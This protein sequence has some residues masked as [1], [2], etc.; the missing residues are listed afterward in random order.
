ME[1]TIHQIGE[2]SD[3]KE[4]C[5]EGIQWISFALSTAHTPTSITYH[6]Y[7]MGGELAAFWSGRLRNG[8]F[9]TVKG[10]PIYT[11]GENRTKYI[12]WSIESFQYESDQRP[13]DFPQFCEVKLKG[14]VHQF[15]MFDKYCSFGLGVKPKDELI[16][17]NLS[18]GSKLYHMKP[19]QN[20]DKVLIFAHMSP[21]RTATKTYYN[22]Y[23]DR[24]Y[25]YGSKT[26][27]PRGIS[28]SIE[29]TTL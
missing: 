1:A 20:K 17:F 11:T 10:Y 9:V 23:V 14:Y 24:V 3:L 13:T 19:I 8:D 16:F 21:R 2:I 26:S 7:L 12:K 15:K 22:W 25:N 5:S 29:T 4:G 6:N 28:H 27:R 18:M